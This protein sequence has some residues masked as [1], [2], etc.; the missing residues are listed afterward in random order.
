MEMLEANGFICEKDYTSPYANIV[1]KLSNYHGVVIRSRIPMDKALLEANPHLNFIARSGAGLENIDLSTAKEVGIEVISS[2]EG[3]MD[4]V[5]EHAIGML[6][7]LFNKLGTANLEVKNGQWRREENRGLELSGKTIGIIGFGK[8]GAA[9]AKKLRG[10]DCQIMAYDKYKSNYAPEYVQETSLEDLQK[11]ADIIS[12]HLPLSNETI[13]YVDKAFIEA[14]ENPFFLINTARG[15]NVD[16]E[17]LVVGLEKG[18]VCGACLD[19]LEYEK[20]S[21]QGLAFD[22]LPKPFQN[23]V[24]MDNV[25]LSP[26]VAG[27]TVE[28]YVKLSQYLGDKILAQF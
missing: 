23:L 28:S 21:L 26:H 7:M 19:V 10:F 25:I 12:I 1:S 17:A 14:I 11:N 4:A 13:N 22:K 20:K 16:T 8:M 18:K 24:E 27:W 9:L 2:P 6:L 5:G 15:N 3:N